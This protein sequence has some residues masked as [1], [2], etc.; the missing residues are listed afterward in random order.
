MAPKW[1]SFGSLLQTQHVCKTLSDNRH[2]LKLITEE[3]L[4]RGSF[5]IAA[6]MSHASISNI[7]LV[8]HLGP[9]PTTFNITGKTDAGCRDCWIR[10]YNAIVL[11]L[12]RLFKLFLLILLQGVRLVVFPAPCTRGEG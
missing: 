1:D 9:C 6:N 11:T 12:A 5:H 3:R 8:S 4:N 2:I 7:V 10:H